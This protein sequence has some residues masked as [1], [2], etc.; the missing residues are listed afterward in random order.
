[1]DYEIGRLRD[2]GIE[3]MEGRTRGDESDQLSPSR[4][5]VAELL[6]STST[7]LCTCLWETIRYQREFRRDEPV[8]STVPIPFVAVSYA[9]ASALE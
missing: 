3:E 7:I 6:N 1:M 9:S 4:F 8:L 5:S 2:E